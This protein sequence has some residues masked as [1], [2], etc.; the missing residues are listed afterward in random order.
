MHEHELAP[1]DDPLYAP[2]RGE[3]AVLTRHS[4]LHRHGS[5][6]P[7]GHWH[8]HLSAT[9]HPIAEELMIEPPLHEH[10][11]K[12][13]ARTALI[14]I[15]G[16]SPMVEG[17]PAFLRCRQVWARPHRRDGAGVRDQHDRDLHAA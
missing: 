15:L 9:A 2:L 10:R 6:A 11:H 1:A 14:L 7:H 17:I 3:T 4:H 16:S 13:S 8:D 5:G 12:T